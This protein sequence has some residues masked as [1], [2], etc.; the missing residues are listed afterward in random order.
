MISLV[1]LT[2]DELRE[3]YEALRVVRHEKFDGVVSAA[4]CAEADS[5][6]LD[7]CV[8]RNDRAFGWFAAKTSAP[9][10]PPAV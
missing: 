8:E 9:A 2:G 7:I 10:N 1:G 4:L 5:L 3:L 6:A